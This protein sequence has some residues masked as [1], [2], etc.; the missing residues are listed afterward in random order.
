M[1]RIMGKGH[2]RKSLGDSYSCPKDIPNK[3]RGPDFWTMIRD[4]AVTS[5]PSL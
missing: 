3:S 4:T 5:D 1:V 2:S